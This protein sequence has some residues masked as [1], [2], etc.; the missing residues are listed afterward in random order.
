MIAVPGATPTL[1]SIVVAPVFVTVVAPKT[2][3]L[4]AVPRGTADWA[5]EHTADKRNTLKVFKSLPLPVPNLH[6][7]K[8][9]LARRLLEI[10]FTTVAILYLFVSNCQV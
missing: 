7:G 8:F 2:A 4:A 9:D 10:Y 1:P 5:N 6:G 3:K